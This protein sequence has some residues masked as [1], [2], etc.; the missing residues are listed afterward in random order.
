MNQKLIERLQAIK[1]FLLDLDGT[2]YLDN[3]PIPDAIEFVDNLKRCGIDYL[4]LTNNS[5]K[6]AAEYVDKLTGMGFSVG[7]FWFQD[8]N[9]LSER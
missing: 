2:V 6:S 4:F 5:S 3:N 7:T 8:P 1:L 9:T